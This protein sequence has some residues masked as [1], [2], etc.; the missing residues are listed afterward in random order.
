[1]YQTLVDST[2]ILREEMVIDVIALV[3]LEWLVHLP[4]V[5]QNAFLTKTAH[6]TKHAD[7]KNVW[8]PVLVYVVS[9]QIAE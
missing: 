9:M 8:I 1:M 7:N 3:F 4:T 6:Q 2:P 5:D